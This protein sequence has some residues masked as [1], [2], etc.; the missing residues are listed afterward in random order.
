MQGAG[1]GRVRVCLPQRVQGSHAELLQ[2]D[3]FRRGA[4]AGL[5]NFRVQVCVREEAAGDDVGPGVRH[6]VLRAVP[7]IED[8]RGGD[9][10]C[11]EG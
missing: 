2:R 11:R 8:E 7:D 3:R 9:R 6:P 10:F 1:G 4:S 5:R